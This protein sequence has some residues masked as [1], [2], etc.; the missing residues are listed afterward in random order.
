MTLPDN[1]DRCLGFGDDPE[2]WLDECHT[3]QRRTS[4][5]GQVFMKPPA[6]IAFFCEFVIP[7]DINDSFSSPRP[8]WRA[9]QVMD[10]YFSTLHKTPDQSVAA[11]LR[12]AVAHVFSKPPY[13]EDY[14]EF[15]QGAMASYI[16]YKDELLAIVT[17]LEALK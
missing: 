2:D 4:P 6:I 5:G 12:A 13:C 7:E 16:K 17:E 14:D 10:A 8:T 3:C 1:I 15:G 9:L 11:A